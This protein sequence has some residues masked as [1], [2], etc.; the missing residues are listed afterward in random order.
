MTT[1]TTTG[2]VDTADAQ[3]VQDI[4]GTDPT[5]ET[6]VLARGVRRSFEGREVLAG[7]DLRLGRGEFVAMLGRSGSG[8]STLL[9]AIAGLDSDFQG[10]LLVPRR[11]SVVFQDPR[12][13]PWKRVLD[14]VVLGLPGPRAENR[15]RGLAALTEV[16]LEQHAKAW[17]VTLSGGEAQRAALAR[18]LVREPE[19][20][21]LDEPFGA[22][23][24]LTRV[25]MHGLLREL[26]R[27]HRPAVLLVTHDVDEA[28]LLADRIVVL[29]E[30]RLG[31]AHE[32]R[33]PK[34]RPRSH[35]EFARLRSALLAELG[36]R[37][38]P[39]EPGEPG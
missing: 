4:V 29:T 6:A 38:E 1:A 34:E 39:A 36:V 17:P 5:P 9:R 24:A 15:A 30:G 31:T 14:N 10:Q 37:E 32:A 3:P 8:K 13:Q 2:P 12:L 21:L 23:D 26:C 25:R 33:V 35:P 7:L 22:L 16:G 19:L 28:V 18:A 27:R 20:L 11:R